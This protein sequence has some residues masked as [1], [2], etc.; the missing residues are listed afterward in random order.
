MDHREEMI[1]KNAHASDAA[2]EMMKIAVEHGLTVEETHIA[3]DK[4][5]AMALDAPT[6]LT[7]RTHSIAYYNA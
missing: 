6:A 3:A 2:I 1:L 4:L 7:S 5:K